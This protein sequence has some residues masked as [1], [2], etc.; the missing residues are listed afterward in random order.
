MTENITYAVLNLSATPGPSHRQKGNSKDNQAAPVYAEVKMK[1]LDLPSVKSGAAPGPIYQE[2]KVTDKDTGQPG[3]RKKH[4]S[5]RWV[6]ALI[7]V[8]VF[9][10]VN[11]IIV[12]V[13]LLFHGSGDS[14]KSA[15]NSGANTSTDCSEEWMKHKDSCYYFSNEKVKFNW[16]NSRE[17]CFKNKSDLVIINDTE[18][19]DFL[20]ATQSEKGGYYFIGMIYSGTADKEW[21]WINKSQGLN[22]LLSIKR[23]RT[24]HYCAVIGFHKVTSAHCEEISTSL[25]LCEK[26]L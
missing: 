8:M 12:G 9:L 18:E 21:I 25:F 7:A 2:T 20:N 1:P 26:K 6:L 22:K 17:E 11:G 14:N 24:D 15:G 16:N 13:A 5:K 3:P 10:I 19:L 23:D 4:C